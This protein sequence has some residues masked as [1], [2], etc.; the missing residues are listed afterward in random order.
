M[1]EYL[2]TLK[3]FCLDAIEQNVTQEKLIIVFCIILFFTVIFLKRDNV[4]F[5]FPSYIHKRFGRIGYTCL[6]LIYGFTA[7]IVFVPLG[8][9]DIF[10]L[11][12]TMAIFAFDNDGSH[13]Y[14]EGDKN[15]K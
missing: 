9:F 14:K 12:M 10:S 13:L 15:R 4:F 11:L 2:I 8:G 5:S 3:E 6:M 1:T 7:W